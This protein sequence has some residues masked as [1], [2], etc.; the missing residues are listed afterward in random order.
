VRLDDTS[1]GSGAS[2]II[3]WQ[4]KSK[5]SP[6]L[7]EAVMISTGSGRNLS[8][9]SRA[10]EMLPA[11]TKATIDAKPVESHSE[12]APVITPIE[13]DPANSQPSEATKPATP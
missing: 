8:F 11:K 1:G 5:V 4:A 13:V 10:I 2:F 7:V 12:T 6:P 9:V 3:E